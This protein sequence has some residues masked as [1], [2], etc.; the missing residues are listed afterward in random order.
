MDNTVSSWIK[1]QNL[2]NLHFDPE[3]D[4]IPKLHSQKSKLAYAQ[5]HLSWHYLH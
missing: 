3:M 4:I 2:F 1:N 5:S